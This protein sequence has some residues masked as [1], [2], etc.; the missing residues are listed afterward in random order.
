MNKAIAIT[1]LVCFGVSLAACGVKRDLKL[2][3]QIEQ[4]EKKKQMRKEGAV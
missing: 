1:L 3:S 4:Q 2:P